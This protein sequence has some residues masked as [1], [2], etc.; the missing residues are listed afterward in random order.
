MSEQ[1]TTLPD[2]PSLDT[3]EFSELLQKLTADPAVAG[4][5]SEDLCQ[6][7]PRD[8]TMIIYA[9]HRARRP[10][11]HEQKPAS[12]SGVKPCPICTED[13]TAIVDYAP[14]SEG[15]TFISQNMYPVLYP[16]VHTE[17]LHL[18][19]PLYDD[20]DH[21]GRAAFGLHL[22][23]WTS[24]VHSNDWHNMPTEDLFITLSR[25]AALENKLL[26]TCEDY[27]P[28][29]CETDGA[30]G[31]LS[32]IKNYGPDAGASLSHGH[33]QIAY[34]NIMPQRTFNNARFFDRHN[35]TFCSYMHEHNPENLTVAEEGSAKVIIPYY[36]RRPYNLMILLDTQSNH[37]SKQTSGQLWDL[38]RAIQKVIKSLHLL[39]PSMGKSVSFNM[40]IHTGPRCELYVEFFPIVQA[41]GG[42][43]RI[44]LWISQLTPRS[45]ASRFKA[46]YESLA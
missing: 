6:L 43:E 21:L 20:P 3:T 40:A 25:L 27:M 36:M 30:R 19:A 45:A 7:D 13:L 24:S 4:Q 38:T 10:N 41:L 44:G 5:A 12:T 42:Y 1:I 35:R 15:F 39:L 46:M 29:S 9:E 26:F 31:Y 28:I 32:I 33:Q 2:Y 22:L 23:Q 18:K 11:E 37:L 14:L 16:T 17:D 34:S 8:G